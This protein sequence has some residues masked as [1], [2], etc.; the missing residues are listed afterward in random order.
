MLNKIK[1]VVFFIA[2]FF[3]L[4]C[5]GGKSEK[6]SRDKND[7]ATNDQ[8]MEI[9]RLLIKKD[10]LKIQNYISRAGWK[11]TETE[12][13]LWYE[14][15]EQGDGPLVVSGTVVV[16]NYTLALMEGKVCYSSDRLGPKEFLVG[17]GNVEA[18]LE[19]GVLLLREG[20]KARFV[21]PPHLAYGLPGDGNKIPARAILVYNVELVSVT[22]P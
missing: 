2:W 1:Y 16:L 19:Q 8:L 13:G 5:N 4:S 21:L 10:Q 9:N 20:A 22:R 3:L 11:M 15:L 17:K 14:I 18:G 6:I 7:R 12:T